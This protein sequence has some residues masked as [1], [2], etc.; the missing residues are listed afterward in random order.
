MPAILPGINFL[1][2]LPGQTDDSFLGDTDFLRSVYEKGFMLRRINIRAALFPD[3]IGGLRANWTSVSARNSFRKFKETVRNEFDIM[4]LRRM[5]PD[6]TIIKGI[7]VETRNG[8]IRFGRQIGS[9][10]ILVGIGNSAEIGSFVDV[11]ITSVSSR[12]VGGFTVPFPVNR[13]PYRDLISLPGIGKKRAA[14]IFRKRPVSRPDLRSIM[15][16]DHPVLDH[17]D[18]SS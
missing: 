8:S 18:F 9:Y 17:L 16:G 3:G 1:G 14:A 12:S 4:F 15:E 13:V 11:A 5:L 6:Y 10:P 7:F 2:A